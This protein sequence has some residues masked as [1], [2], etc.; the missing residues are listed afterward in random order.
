MNLN[1]DQFKKKILM[2]I[3]KHLN[4]AIYFDYVF[5]LSYLYSTYYVAILWGHFARH[6]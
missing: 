4:A 2:H 6:K 1:T 5:F 3:N